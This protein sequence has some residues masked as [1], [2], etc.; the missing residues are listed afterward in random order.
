[1]WVIINTLAK[2]SE[3]ED[4]VIFFNAA[5]TL[6]R[7]FYETEMARETVEINARYVGRLIAKLKE[8]SR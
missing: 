1:L 8:A 2:E 3:D 6:H 7:N 5:N 4:L